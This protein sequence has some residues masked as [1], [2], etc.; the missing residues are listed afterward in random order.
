MDLIFVLLCIGVVILFLFK[1]KGLIATSSNSNSTEEDIIEAL[2]AGHKINA[3]KHYRA[4]HG[5]GLREAKDAVEEMEI[6]L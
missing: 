4:V 6:P 3:I 2:K 5:V 1:K